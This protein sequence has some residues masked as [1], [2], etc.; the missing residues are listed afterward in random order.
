MGLILS[1]WKQ[2]ISSLLG[3]QM[4]VARER[5]PGWL[6]SPA[7]SQ[8]LSPY[9]SKQKALHLG[10]RPEQSQVTGSLRKFRSE[11]SQLRSSRSRKPQPV[12]PAV[13]NLSSVPLTG[14]DTRRCVPLHQTRKQQGKWLNMA[15]Q[16]HETSP[17]F[18]LI[19][20]K[21]HLSSLSVCGLCLGLKNSH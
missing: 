10:L 6:C 9:A 21:H 16:N 7:M 13:M 3:L 15:T 1:E 19:W 11:N 2:A 18:N 5:N 14:Q 20:A 17:L 8:A 12:W 4:A